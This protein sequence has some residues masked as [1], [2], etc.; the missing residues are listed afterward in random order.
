M[1]TFT[2]RFTALWSGALILFAIAEQSLVGAV[3]RYS[4][5]VTLALAIGVTLL[6]LFPRS[7]SSHQP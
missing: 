4:V 6:L 3:S 5:L 1:Y 2:L 7:V